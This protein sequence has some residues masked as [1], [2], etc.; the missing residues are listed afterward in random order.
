MK[1]TDKEWLS[2][3]NHCRVFSTSGLFH[4][5]PNLFYLVERESS[6]ILLPYHDFV[7]AHILYIHTKFLSLVVP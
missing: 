2:M 7:Y 4:S 5:K 6:C 3:L 1:N